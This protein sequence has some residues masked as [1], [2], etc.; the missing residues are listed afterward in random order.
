MALPLELLVLCAAMF[1]GCFVAGKLAIMLQGRVGVGGG[2]LLGT[3]LTLILPEGVHALYSDPHGHHPGP[4][5]PPDTPPAP[6][7]T[8]APPPENREFVLGLSVLLGFIFIMLTERLFGGGGEGDLLPSPN[9]PSLGEG[10][11][12]V[13]PVILTRRKSQFSAII[14]LMVHSA[15]DGLALGAAAASHAAG[16]QLWVFVA[17]MAHKAPTAFSFI[18][19]LLQHARKP[20][21]VRDANTILWLFAMAAPLG[22]LATYA[23][24]ALTGLS[25]HYWSAVGLLFS[26]GTFLNVAT[27]HVL[28]SVVAAAQAH[29]GDCSD[30]PLPWR[31]L[32]LFCGGAFLPLLFSMGHHH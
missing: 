31:Q 25:G 27:L 26:C 5:H 28:P 15:A 17:L 13:G 22:A 8:P 4:S 32:F 30:G 12:E 16:L 21:D 11:D 3:A 10:E 18:N 19:F 2:V 1:L 24:M 9:S 29:G 6:S 14:G 20:S 23:F 7:P